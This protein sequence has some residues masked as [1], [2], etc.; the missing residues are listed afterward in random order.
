MLQVYNTIYIVGVYGMNVIICIDDKNG[1]LFN[2]R[3]Q[4]K[5]RFIQEHIIHMIGNHHFW[6]NQYTKNQFVN[7][8]IDIP[9]INVTEDFLEK[10]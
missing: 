5:D 2:H 7:V 9:Q 6:M 8:D 1:V 3:R 10:A 4:S